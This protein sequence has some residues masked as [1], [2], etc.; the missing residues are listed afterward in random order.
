MQNLLVQTKMPFIS[1]GIVYD[2][3]D[4]KIFEENAKEFCGYVVTRKLFVSGLKSHQ[5]E[6]R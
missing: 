3:V 6:V 2:V 5:A 1:D 4:E